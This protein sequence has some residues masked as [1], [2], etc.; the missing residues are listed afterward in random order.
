MKRIIF[1]VLALGLSMGLMA[2]KVYNG[3]EPVKGTFLGGAKSG[4]VI[5]P[6]SFDDCAS[7]DAPLYYLAD[8]QSLWEGMSGTNQYGDL[9]YGQR[10]TGSYQ[11]TGVAAVMSTLS[12]DGTVE[13]LS[14]A[15]VDMDGNELAS[16]AFSTA[17]LPVAT[18]DF[19]FDLVEFDFASPVTASDFLA[20]VGVTPFQ[21]D[22]AGN[23]F[24]NFTFI[25]ST[26]MGCWSDDMAYS[27]SVLSEGAPYEWVSINEAWGGA[28]SGVELDLF[29]FPKVSGVGLSEVELNSLSY[30]YPNPAKEEVMLASSV[31]VEK[32]EIYNVLGQVVYSAD[33]N[34]NSVKVNT[35]DFAAGNYVVKMY[36]EAGVATKKLVVE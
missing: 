13:E 27:Y 12:V 2:Q 18:E 25:A 10:Y 15:V 19:N 28:E 26:E 14:A 22:E 31:N 33:V 6:E 29:I 35:A 36:T 34:A 9:A 5:Y 4:S 20:T 8:G 3:A 32:V 21:Y 24:G 30:V 23:I 11:V 1:S 7:I 17:D 16:V